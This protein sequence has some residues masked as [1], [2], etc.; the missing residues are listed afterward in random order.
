MP[1]NVEVKAPVTD[2]EFIVT[3]A[4]KLGR[5]DGEDRL[6]QIMGSGRILRNCYVCRIVVNTRRH[7]L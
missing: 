3:V 2:L 4:K 6:V 5:S 7:I 1:R